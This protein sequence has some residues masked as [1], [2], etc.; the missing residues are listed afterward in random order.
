MDNILEKNLEIVRDPVHFL[1]KDQVTDG[2]VRLFKNSAPGIVFDH[3]GKSI[4]FTYLLNAIK[5]TWILQ[6][7]EHQCW[8]VKL[9]KNK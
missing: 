2:G 7:E 4:F 5:I 9:A 6:H 3:K 1:E 8:H